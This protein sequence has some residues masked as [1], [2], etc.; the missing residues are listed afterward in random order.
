MPDPG[1]TD[2]THILSIV[3]QSRTAVMASI[4][5]QIITS[6]LYV[7]ALFLL[8]RTSFRQKRSTMT[9]IILLAVGV[10]GL[11]SD[12]FFH[13]LA[14]FMTDDS[15]TIQQ[16]VVQVMDFM[17][18]TGVAFLLPILLPF[19]IGSLVLA[20]GLNKQLLITRTSML[21]IITSFSIGILG[22]L[23]K[24]TQ[25]GEPAPMIVTLGLFAIGQAFI[26]LDL[27]KGSHKVKNAVLAYQYQNWSNK[28]SNK[29][30]DEHGE[31]HNGVS[32]TIW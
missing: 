19:F 17:Q 15:V 31:D 2:T 14:Y 23:A 20:M 10:L 8:T 24:K 29:S 30:A 21:I 32:E 27:I 26:G 3:R 22:A 16:D 13:L 11:C 25:I 7:I 28:S 5:V 4:I 1:T 6:I 18:T 12:A 9:G